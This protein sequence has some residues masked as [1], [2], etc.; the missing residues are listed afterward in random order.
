LHC[1]VS[2]CLN[3]FCHFFCCWGLVSFHCDLIWCRELFRFSWICWDLL[4]ILIYDLFWGKFCEL[5]KRMCI[6]KMLGEI[7]CRYQSRLFG[8]MCSV[9][10][11]FLCW[12]FIWMTYLL[13]IVGFSGLPLSLC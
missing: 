6:A 7:L 2:I 10:H 8:L 5:K 13:V 1:S 12:F 9:A 11:K 4:C 3:I